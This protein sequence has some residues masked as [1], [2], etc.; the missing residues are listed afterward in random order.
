MQESGDCNAKQCCRRFR[1][2]RIHAVTAL[3][4]IAIQQNGNC[5]ITMQKHFATCFDNAVFPVAAA[6]A[7]PVLRQ[8]GS[9]VMQM[10]TNVAR[11]VHTRTRNMCGRTLSMFNLILHKIPAY[12]YHPCDNA[13]VGYCKCRQM[14]PGLCTHEQETCVA[15]HCRRLT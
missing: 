7:I 13:E 2:C 12:T 14:L 8:C 6:I 4:H 5:V 11:L 15:V 1:Q 9:S 3:T 10:S